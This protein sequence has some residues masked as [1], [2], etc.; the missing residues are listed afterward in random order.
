MPGIILSFVPESCSG[1]RV[2]GEKPGHIL[3]GL[4]AIGIYESRYFRILDTALGVVVQREET[5]VGFIATLSM[6]SITKVFL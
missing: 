4:R 6:I 3:R 2:L 1:S 5:S